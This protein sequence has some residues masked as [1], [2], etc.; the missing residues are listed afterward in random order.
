[1]EY[2]QELQYIQ[3]LQYKYKNILQIN[4]HELKYIWKSR[5]LKNLMHEYVDSFSTVS[6]YFNFLGSI[7]IQCNLEHD[8]QNWEMK[9]KSAQ[10][11]SE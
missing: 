6:F 8:L 9:Y 3:Q 2:V 11:E 1:M 5:L 7:C 10:A 4:G